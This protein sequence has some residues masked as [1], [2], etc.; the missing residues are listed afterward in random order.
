M[1]D[2]EGAECPAC[3][4]PRYSE[5]YE[6]QWIEGG[7]GDVCPTCGTETDF[8]PTGASVGLDHPTTDTG[9]DGGPP[10]VSVHDLDDDPDRCYLFAFPSDADPETVEPVARAVADSLE[11]AQAVFVVADVESDLEI[12]ELDYGDLPETAPSLDTAGFVCEEC[13]HDEHA[14]YGDF[15]VCKGCGAKNP[16]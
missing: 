9:G 16:A 2:D 6:D 11:W 7:D 5:R 1:V 8:G 14:V 13:G 3:G 10:E 4:T 15:S 12:D